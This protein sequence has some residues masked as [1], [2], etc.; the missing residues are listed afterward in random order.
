[1]LKKGADPNKLDSQQT[2]A[3]GA[4]IKAAEMIIELSTH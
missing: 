1:M 2:N 3:W 4:A